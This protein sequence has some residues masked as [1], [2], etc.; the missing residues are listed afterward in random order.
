MVSPVPKGKFMRKVKLIALPSKSV[1][2]DVVCR[3]SSPLA[4]PRA[5]VGTSEC[6]MHGELPRG[7]PPPIWVGNVG[8]GTGSSPAEEPVLR[9]R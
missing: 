7:P 9:T 8:A 1:C 6:R 2:L 5:G 3:L 4:A